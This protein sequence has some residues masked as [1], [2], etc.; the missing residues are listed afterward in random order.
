[1]VRRSFR[2]HLCKL[3]SHQASLSVSHF[4]WGQLCSVQIFCD[5]KD[6]WSE[7]LSASAHVYYWK[8]IFK[9]SFGDFRR[10]FLKDNLNALLFRELSWAFKINFDS[11]SLRFLCV[12]Q[13]C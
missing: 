6:P 12:I 2:V 9:S 4:F 8:A 10:L 3:D 1:M 5:I 11:I 7:E 13:E